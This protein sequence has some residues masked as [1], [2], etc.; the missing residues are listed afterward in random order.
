MS[1]TTNTSITG[2]WNSCRLCPHL[3]YQSCQLL[4]LMVAGL[5]KSTTEKLQRVMNAA[6]WLVTNTRKFDHD[7]TYMRCHLLHWLDVSDRIKFRLC[8]TVYKCVHRL[9]ELCRPVSALQGRRHLRSAGRGHLHFPRVRRASYV[10][11]SFSYAGPSA[12]NSLPDNLRDTSLSLSVF[13]VLN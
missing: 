2:W 3:Y 5:P 12:W 6:A 9:T 7:L 4:H 11:R 13:F 8:V 10:K 1:T